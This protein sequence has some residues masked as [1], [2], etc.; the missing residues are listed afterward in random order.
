MT[1][2]RGVQK[3]NKGGGSKLPFFKVI[4]NYQSDCKYKNFFIYF[5]F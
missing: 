4:K 2:V 1:L 5:I 3:N